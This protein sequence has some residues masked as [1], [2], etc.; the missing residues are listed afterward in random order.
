MA[1]LVLSVTVLFT[2]WYAFRG[3]LLPVFTPMHMI[4]SMAA[5]IVLFFLFHLVRDFYRSRKVTT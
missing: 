3:R 5:F 4:A 1:I 2:L